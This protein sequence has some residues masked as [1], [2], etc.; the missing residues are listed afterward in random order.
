MNANATSDSSLSEAPWQPDTQQRTQS[1]R[2]T[3]FATICNAGAF[4]QNMLN[5]N[6]TIRPKPRKSVGA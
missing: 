2:L 1:Q 3:R 6:G 5:I 4:Q